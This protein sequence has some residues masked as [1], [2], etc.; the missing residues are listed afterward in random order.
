M[1][2]DKLDAADPS[3]CTVLC[4][5]EDTC[6]TVAEFQ[7]NVNGIDG[8]NEKTSPRASV[9]S[10]SIVRRK[11]RQSW[12]VGWLVIL[13]VV[14]LLLLPASLYPFKNTQERNYSI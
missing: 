3:S 4:V 13:N 5:R 2:D 6:G 12:L 8:K 1:I 10:P 14:E 11:S 9:G 7:D